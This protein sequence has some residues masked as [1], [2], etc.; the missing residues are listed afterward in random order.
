MVD[1]GHPDGVP[2]PRPGPVSDE[3]TRILGRSR[4]L[5]FLGDGPLDVHVTNGLAFLDDIPESAA[6]LDLGSGGG[7]PGLVVAVCRPDLTILLVDGAVR[8]TRFLT[9]AVDELGIDGRVRVALGRAEELA[10]A[11]EWRHTFDV[12]TARSFGPPAVTAECAVGFL[13]GPGSLLLVSEPP[14]GSAGR[15]PAD[16]LGSLG[17]V[18]GRRRSVEGAT[19]QRLDAVTACSERYPRRVGIPAKRPLFG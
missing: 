11:P 14:M 9:E 17:L 10:R 5:G 15:W 6:V 12:V 3:L 13:K 1:D 2:V 7:V 18:P 8:R 19:I 16:G 4:E